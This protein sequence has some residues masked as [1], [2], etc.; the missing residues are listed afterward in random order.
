MIKRPTAF[1]LGAGASRPYG[2]PTARE[3]LTGVRKSLATEQT[4][5]V[6]LLDSDFNEAEIESLRSSLIGSPVGS[7]DEFLEI[8]DHARLVKVGKAAIAAYLLPREVALNLLPDTQDDD[9]YEYLFRRMKEGAS[10]LNDF[11]QNAISFVTFNYDRS[12]EKFLFGSLCSTYGATPAQVATAWKRARMQIVHVYGSF[13]PLPELGGT[14][15]YG[16][17]PNFSGLLLRQAADSIHIVGEPGAQAGIDAAQDV[18]MRCERVCFL[19][20]GYRPA[21]VDRLGLKTTLLKDVRVFGSS[22]K[23]LS[24]ERGD[25]KRM[26]EA[27]GHDIVLANP[28]ANALDAL[29]ALPVLS[30]FDLADL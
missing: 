6:R 21:N 22:Y 18:L 14:L 9:W 1:V 2:F 15:S 5:R 24:G 23:T 17:E 25:I 16:V 29:R 11:L 13:G 3:L 30:P 28:D 20:F 8:R 27:V 10:T 19:G 26:F 4:F 12:V 7:V